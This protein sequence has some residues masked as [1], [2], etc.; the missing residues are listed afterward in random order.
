MAWNRKHVNIR[1]TSK[2]WL[3]S[4]YGDR[5]LA[6]KSLISK[7]DSL[8]IHHKHDFHST[9]RMLPR[10]ASYDDKLAVSH[11]NNNNNQSS[12]QSHQR[13]CSA[14]N[15]NAATSSFANSHKTANHNNHRHDL[16]INNVNNITIRDHQQD[17]SNDFSSDEQLEDLYKPNPTFPIQQQPTSLAIGFG[18]DAGSGDGSGSNT[19]P[20]SLSYHGLII[21]TSSPSPRRQSNETD[22]I[23]GTSF[24]FSKIPSNLQATFAEVGYKLSDVLLISNADIRESRGNDAYQYLLFQQYIIYYLAI[25]TIFCMFV[26]LPVNIFGDN[27]EINVSIFESFHA[28]TIRNLNDKSYYWI[29]VCGASIMSLIGVFNMHQFTK[30]IRLDDE[31]ITRRTLLIRRVPKGKRDKEHLANY[32]QKVIPNCEI[33]GIQP[34]YDVRSLAP[35]NNELI[36]IDNAR[37]Y[38][39]EYLDLK[40]NKLEIRPSACGEFGCLFSHCCNSCRKVDGLE[41]YQAKREE[42]LNLIQIE[43]AKAASHPSDGF[44]IT[45]RTE[46]MA[47]QAFVH[48]KRK[49]ERLFSLCPFSRSV[50]QLSSWY[51]RL[52][53]IPEKDELNV[54]LWM[55]NYAPYPDDINWV[56]ITVN[57]KRQ[58]L[59]SIILNL[60][61][62]LLFMFFSTPTV[63]MRFYTSNLK[64]NEKFNQLYS[65]SVRKILTLFETESKIIP[66]L[67]SPLILIVAASA[68]P[69]IV[70]LTCQYIAYISLSAKNNAI[71]WK[72]YLFLIFMVVIWP[73]ITS[74]SIGTWLLKLIKE[75]HSDKMFNWECLFGFDNNNLA[76][77]FN[78]TIQSAFIGNIMELMR[79]PELLIY[80]WYMATARSRAEVDTASRYVV[81]DFGIGIRYPRFLLI[82][83]MVV[84]YSLS[85]PLITLAGL[86]Y[87]VIKHLIDRYNIYYVYNPSKINSK[88]HSTAITFVH[89]A[90][91]MMQAQL[92]TVTYVEARYTPVFAMSLIALVV[93]ILI[94]AGHFFF[95]MFRNLNHL[96]YRATRKHA[97]TQREYCACSYLPPICQPASQPSYQPIGRIELGTQFD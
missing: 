36:N 71:M 35:L 81:W 73:P 96:T 16:I 21:N 91:L 64:E 88:I 72:V 34:V 57:L 19:N 62:L 11:S 50:A 74:T 26:V 84:T 15:Y 9:Y 13:A 58:W 75:K 61:A 76:F 94:F 14:G 95:Q 25:L 52:A 5:K 53:K 18:G 77:F 4:I 31:Q 85:C 59:R 37:S 66:D 56:D 49:Q 80:I 79:I 68:L 63:I 86:V 22:G 47:Q 65:N 69:A 33:E 60:L 20:T 23:L 30:R 54:G 92:F 93:S 17:T 41:F 12:K 24:D 82:F 43:T 3:Q 67:I 29:H 38:C 40:G 39:R 8:I 48:L 70:T 78:Y 44:F 45:F 2:G 46:R 28:T 6:T 51:R 87:M 83:A 90:F 55:V 97:D 10:V 42:L 1:R 32:F 27:K 7:T 89:I